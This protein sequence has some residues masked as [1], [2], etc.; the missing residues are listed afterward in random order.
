MTANTEDRNY[1]KIKLSPLKKIINYRS[2]I[3][4]CTREFVGRKWLRKEFDNFLN[5]KE[6]R[7]FLIL[8][9]PGSGKTAFLA[10]LI[11]RRYYP[12]H[13]IGS[14]H[15]FIDEDTQVFVVSNMDWY[16][17]VRFAESIGYQLLRDYGGWVMD[18]ESWGIKID[19]KIKSLD[20]FLTGAKIKEFKATPR[21]SEKPK[22]SIRQEI[23]Q[24]NSAANIVGVYIEKWSADVEQVVR[25]LLKTPLSKIA[26]KWP[27][28][29][30]VVAIDGLDEAKNY[31]SSDRTICKIL[32]A[33]GLPPSIRFLLASR[34]GRHIKRDLKGQS[35]VI[36]LS[37]NE[38][39]ERDERT[40]ADAKEYVNRLAEEENIKEM[41]EK[42][43]L[44]KD[45]FID[46]VVE[47]SEGNF[48]YLHI[49]A[50]EL[51]GNNQTLLNLKSLPNGLEGIYG[52]FLLK[53]RENLKSDEFWDEA[54]KPVLGAMAVAR[55]PLTRSQ[56]SD[57]SGT[58][59]QTVATVITN[60]KEFMDI[61]GERP[62]GRRYKIYQRSFS[63]Y[64]I[65]ENNEDYIGAKLPN[66]K[67]VNYYMTKDRFS[68]DNYAIKYLMAHMI[69]AKAW[70]ELEELVQHINYLEQK[71]KQQYIFQ[72][73]IIN[74][75]LNKEISTARLV[76]ILEQILQT[77][78]KN[79]EDTKEKADWLDIFSYW[80]NEFGKN[81]NK[82]RWD[83]VKKIANK[84]DYA[85]GTL[86]RDL[87]IHYKNTG[88]ND[89]ALRFAELATWV[90]QRAND[91]PKCVEACAF[92]ERLCQDEGMEEAYKTLGRAEFL[93]MRARALTE[94]SNTTDDRQKERYE[95]EALKAY[96]ELNDAF[97]FNE[98][99]KLELKIDEWQKLEEEK[100]E[101][102]SRSFT[103]NKPVRAQ[104]VSNTHDCISALYII[105][106][107]MKHGI[108]V[109][110]I[111][112]TKFKI[113][114]LAPPDIE[115]TILIGGPK[116][117]G[118]SQVAQKFYKA[119]PDG[120]LELYSAEG[121]IAKTLHIQEEETICYMVGGPSKIN[122][123]KAAYDFT[124]DQE[125]MSLIKK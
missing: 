109:K 81:A 19:Q 100:G 12:H 83:E 27:D 57:F 3:E 59:E 92:A 18:W 82:E 94:L 39:G 98:E 8:G 108:G 35:Q 86:S 10:D 37:E 104:V 32:S 14:S 116:S 88:E 105:Q 21:F 71:R 118:I 48:Q 45:E 23:E 11:N 56:I 122:T 117:P 42:R 52:D 47:A 65:S 89:W 72:D 111:H 2:L 84:F 101:V 91:L 80:I 17:P 99:V 123:L 54:Y 85:C 95:S 55:E 25:Q 26:D 90:Y 103:N 106:N 87:A 66:Q 64:I 16:D 22:L 93:R 63:D 120:F 78:I 112:S 38:K 113:K 70:D 77:I 110:W 44:S 36:W 49:Y 114:D 75:I 102:L 28:I 4:R 121:M 9:E 46:S 13:F 5:Q 125:V 58:Q 62:E 29:N 15:Y 69:T 67:I 73:D 97:R 30:F 60:I 33:I 24:Y 115:F 41:L 79:L 74:L 107:F 96:L 53:I 40:I 50:N 124:N 68:Y 31:S 51:R 119:N 20:G 34:P 7:C 6:P 43:G 76:D 61:I 1:E